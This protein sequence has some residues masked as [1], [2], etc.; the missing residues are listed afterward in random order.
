MNILSPIKFLLPA[1]IPSWN[2]FDV[3][4]PSPFIQFSL[5][6]SNST[7]EPIWHEFRPLPK[8]ISFAQML[9]RMLW[10]SRQNESL[11]LLSCAEKIVSNSSIQIVR[12]C[13]SEI[14][15]RISNDLLQG[16]NNLDLTE[17]MLIQFRLVFVKQKG[18]KSHEDIAFI[19]RVQSLTM[20]T[21]L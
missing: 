14:L 6:K 7:S 5:L 21:E 12:H 13:E 1:L 20:S 2:F 15:E 19:S 17:E 3:I 16:K 18:L 4:S 9:K 10:N 8:H 11:Y